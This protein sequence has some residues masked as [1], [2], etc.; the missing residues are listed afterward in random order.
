MNKITVMTKRMSLLCL[1]LALFLATTRLQAQQKLSASE[2]SYQQARRVLEA[3]IE[4][5]GGLEAIAAIK[6]FTV[7][8]TGKHTRV[9]HPSPEAQYD[10]VDWAETTVLD[11]SGA[12]LHHEI[13]DWNWL[14]IINGNR[15]FTAN[16]A[17]K[18]AWPLPSASVQ[19]YPQAT[20][21]LPHYL[22]REALT[23]RAASLRWLGETQEQDKK[24][25]VI[26]F[27]DKNARQVSL[28]FDTQTHL[29]TK[30][31][32]LY[33]DSVTGDT[34][35]E[36][37][38]P[39]YRRV[40]RFQAPTGLIVR[41]GGRVAQNVRYDRLEINGQ[42][43][44]SIFALPA[45]CEILPPSSYQSPPPLT[46]TKIAND[47]YL[48][49]GVAYSN[50]VLVVAFNDYMLVIESP[51]LG[52]FNHAN[53]QA[54]AKIK[55][56][57]PGK[58]IRYHAFT[59]FHADHGGGARAYI[60]EGATIIVTPG[61][62]QFVE[63][64]AAS[65]FML[66]PDALARNPRQPL[67]EVVKDKKYVIRDDRHLVELYDVGPYPHVKEELI[68]Y[69]PQE[70]L[71]FEGDLFTSGNGDV[72]GPASSAAVLLAEKIR[73]LGLE[74]EKIVGLHGRLR[75]ITDLH[76]ALEKRHQMSMK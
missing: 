16:L 54:I 5:L 65:P 57:F 26:T 46:I 3:G 52:T 71:L 30:Y 13:K 75:P 37:L 38:F 11:F 41:K 17:S 60:A 4:A 48:M 34:L 36:H 64:M 21:K 20:E 50:N 74:V 31:E 10:V 58:P 33:T 7:V 49:H 66:T 28:Y 32:Y 15:G 68:V 55:E 61:N 62:K 47:V 45:G 70:K 1:I 9:E 63:R 8:E 27:S 51:E 22:L 69:L 72:V 19:N 25:Q 35:Q 76:K 44:D 67:I 12:R 53:E 14:T 56:R 6:N 2:K 24:Q 23:Q 42:L 29:L 73:Q 43:A 40:E 59:H 39:G 18:V